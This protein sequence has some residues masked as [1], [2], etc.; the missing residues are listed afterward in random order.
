MIIFLVKVFQEARYADNFVRGKLYAHRLSYFKR[1][2]DRDG[3]RDED[4]GA[5]MLQRDGLIVEFTATNIETGES[6]RI[7]MAGHEFAAPIIMR[8]RWF[9]HINVFCMYAGHSGDF[10]SISDDNVHSFKKQL[11]IPEDGIK[12]GRY[13]VVITNTRE[14]LK[15]VKVAAEK[16][17]YGICGGL[18]KY[19]DAEVGTPPAKSEI[20]SIFTKRKE[21]EYQKEFRLA[22]DTGTMGCNPI[23][24]DI[25]RIGDISVLTNTSD[26]NRQ[27]SVRREPQ[28]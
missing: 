6:S 21:Y 18:V 17:G 24:L 12:L 3:R 4:E 8:P 13:A 14:F 25:G 19:Y 23:T 20:E 22:I 1:I 15:R 10:Q 2:E 27:L 7:T 5:I 28:S 9:D 16:R 11:E 26:I